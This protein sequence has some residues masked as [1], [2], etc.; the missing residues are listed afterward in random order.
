MLR[1]E[2]IS[3]E[4]AFEGKLLRV[5]IDRVR[6]ADGTESTREIVAHPGAVAAVPLLGH[7]VLLVRQWRQA[8]GK[9]MLEIP[10]GTLKPGEQPEDCI[11][12]ELQEEIGHRPGRLTK[13]FALALAPGYSSEIIHI[14]L[15]EDLTPARADADFDER[16]EVVAMPLGELVDRCLGGQVADAKTVAG[17][18][19]AAAKIGL[20]TPASAEQ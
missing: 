10:A 18:L 7:D 14:Y 2:L 8:V 4:T 15:A 17:V 11:V 16:L 3:S 5:R 12:R 6:L 1:E 19:A 9:E 20:L 13:L